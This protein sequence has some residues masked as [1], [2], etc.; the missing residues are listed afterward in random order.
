MRGTV[1]SMN[2]HA[3]RTPLFKAGAQRLLFTAERFAEHE[4][5]NHAAA[6][7]YAF[8]LSATPAVMLVLGLAR[9]ILRRLPRA[10][11]EIE[12]ATRG[13]LGPLASARSGEGFF[14]AGLGALAL[15]IGVV[16]LVWA[17]RLFIVTIQRALRLIHAA[18][19]R[20]A[21]V[22]ENLL[23]FAVELASLVVIVAVLATGQVVRLLILDRTG[24]DPASAS[25]GWTR[26]LVGTAPALALYLFVYL[27][28]RLIPAERPRR[29]TAATTAA[30]VIALFALI[31]SLMD[32]FTNGARYELL[33]GVFGGLIVLLVKVYAFFTL[34]FYGAEYCFVA[35]HFD[36]LLFGRFYRVARAARTGRLERALFMAP[37]RLIAS[38]ARQY[39]AGDLVFSAGSTG[40][41][42]YF[43]YEGEVG[44]YA[45]EAEGSG[46]L[47]LL[48]AGEL[49]GEMA[50]FLDEPR[51]ATVRAESAATL[52]VLPPEIFGLFIRSDAE[53][54]RRLIDSLSARLKAA[55]AALG[56]QKKNGP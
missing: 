31:A 22:K 41:E 47:A 11:A 49:F 20:N 7:A 24:T 55:N 37:E 48:G 35:E 32:L 33:Y 10:V 43:V 6:G 34:Y 36:A 12:A 52:L 42:V 30:L 13:F 19:G 23:T 26:T 5:A 45:A 38:Y 1:C 28:Y 51:T 44:V 39:E 9:A 8:L 18:T 56:G 17:A 4:M 27:T 46:R 14:T 16:S 50:A 40:R 3:E 54:A 29:K 21:A 25:L 53:A 2:T 15:T